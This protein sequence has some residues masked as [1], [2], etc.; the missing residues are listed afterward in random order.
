MRESR[1]F[2]TLSSVSWGAWRN[3]GMP[4]WR[5]SADRTG[6]PANSLLTG[7]LTGKIAISEGQG[8]VL[9]QEAT[10]LQR[11]YI[12]FPARLNREIFLGIREISSRNRE[13]YCLIRP[14]W[15]LGHRRT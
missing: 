1:G 8:L 9:V 2:P 5:C 12:H 3:A 15:D 13:F 10:V 11:F 7:N 4:G 14:L 6:L